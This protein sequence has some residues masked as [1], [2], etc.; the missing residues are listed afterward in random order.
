GLQKGGEQGNDLVEQ[1]SQ[2]CKSQ[3]ENEP[4]SKMYK[5]SSETL[6]AL[7][8]D[9]VDGVLLDSMVLGYAEKQSNGEIEA[10]ETYGMRPVAQ[11]VVKHSG[12]EEALKPALE[13][14][15]E[16]GRYEEIFDK[17]GMSESQI[18]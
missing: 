13:Y 2:E 6:V 12:L 11:G 1:K 17:W 18:D 5:D 15:V 16:S 7:N 14:L 10:V 9:R 4:D 8:S 3:G